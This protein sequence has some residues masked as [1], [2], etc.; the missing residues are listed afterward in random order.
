[1]RGGNASADPTFYGDDAVLAYRTPADERDVPALRPTVTTNAGS[2]DGAA[3]P[4]EDLNTALTVRTPADGSP[5]WIQLAFAEPITVRAL[6][7]ASRGSGV[8]FGR[9][10]A[11]DDASHLRTIVTLPGAQQYRPSSV[12]TYSVPETRARIIR[13]ELT[14]APPSP[15]AVMS[16]APTQPAREYVITE[17]VPHT[18]ARVHRWEEKAGFNFLFEYESSPTPAPPVTSIVSRADVVDLTA[19]MKPDGTLD[20]DV[21][22]GRWTACTSG[23]SRRTAK[24]PGFHS[25]RSRT[26]CSTRSRWT[27]RWASSGSDRSIPG[28]CTT[29]TCAARRR[30]PTCTASRSW[31]RSR[32]PAAVTSRRTRSRRSATTGSHRGSTGWSSTRRRISRSTRSPAT[33]WSARTSIGTSPGPSRPRRS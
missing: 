29:R 6:S 32:G 19:R 13:L 14:S 16:Q 15:A 9:V 5:A 4:D 2:A 21:P 20:W 30:R 8:P 18:G 25:S 33:R 27:S 28:T 3:L 24:R 12:R 22:A 1:A 10:L 26:R 7:L 17:L 31:R 23:R 11:G